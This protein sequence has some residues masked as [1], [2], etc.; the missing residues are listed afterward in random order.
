MCAMLATA[1]SAYAIPGCNMG[2]AV[3]VT[4][5][6]ADVSAV[7]QIAATTGD[8]PIPQHCRIQG[9]TGDA[10]L[11]TWDGSNTVRRP[12]GFEIRLPDTWNGR[13]FF[14]GG[15][16]TDGVVKDATGNLQGSLLDTALGYGYA[17]VSTDAGHKNPAL[18]GKATEPYGILTQFGLDF[19]A[20]KDYGYRALGVVTALS[21]YVISHYYGSQPAKSYFVGCSNGGRQALEVATRFPDEFD[22]I[23]F[24]DPSTSLTNTVLQ[25]ASDAKLLSAVATMPGDALTTSDMDLV[26]Q[27]VTDACDALDGAT[28]GI[29]NDTVRCQST[30]QPSTLLCAAGQTSNCLNQAKYNAL[31]K[32]VAGVR[33]GAGNPYYASWPWE[34]SMGTHMTSGSWRNWRIESIYGLDYPLYIATGGSGLQ[35]MMHTLPIA[36][37]SGSGP[38]SYTYLKNVDIASAYANAQV[39]DSANGFPESAESLYNV[40]HPSDLSAFKTHGKIIA[41]TGAGDPAVSALDVINWYK[42]LQTTDQ[43]NGGKQTQ[44]YA[45]LYVVPGMG[46]C[47]GGRGTDRFN[48]FQVLED[49]VE[50]KPNSTEPRAVPTDTNPPIASFAGTNLD[51]PLAA[52]STSRQRPLCAFPK[53]ARHNGL[54]NS[55]GYL[56][57]IKAA[58]FTC[59]D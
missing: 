3:Y 33:D 39:S 56:D 6:Q 35:Q 49:W 37:T 30:F 42:K 38:S 13:F 51:I 23:L 8:H 19:E 31:T 21:K 11:V 29:V 20:R 28:D 17:V 12:I 18:T 53:V 15:A 10:R 44:D 16:G 5:G 45:R 47:A 59:S 58:A 43:A 27:K 1:G 57:Y 9:T 55:L 2:T 22:G 50:T 26:Q 7:D 14:Q 40:P 36:V 52:W 32:M 34:P 25:A 46:H 4:S 54:R 41:F 48:L 24:G